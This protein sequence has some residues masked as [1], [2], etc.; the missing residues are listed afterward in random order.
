M[1]T[2]KIRSGGEA[3]AL[4]P[5]ETCPPGAIC[6]FPGEW[7]LALRMGKAAASDPGN[8]FWKDL[9]EAKRNLPGYTLF[10]ETVPPPAEQEKLD[11][12]ALGIQRKEPEK[13]EMKKRC[14]AIA[15]EILAELQAKVKR[16]E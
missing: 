4:E 8:T 16:A 14:M 1:R 12:K 10:C 5:G 2:I 3:F 15:Q 6:F 11:F 7:E 9:L 13:S